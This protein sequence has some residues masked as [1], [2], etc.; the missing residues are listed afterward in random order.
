M[1]NKTDINYALSSSCT[2]SKINVNIDFKKVCFFCEKTNHQVCRNLLRVEIPSFWEPLEKLCNERN[3]SY[4]HMKIGGDF[5][6]LAVLEARY[7]KTCHALSI[8]QYNYTKKQND[9]ALYDNALINFHNVYF[10]PLIKSGRA[11]NMRTLLQKYQEQHII[12]GISPSDAEN[13]R[14]EKLK[15]C[16]TSKYGS[17]LIFASQKN[18]SEPQ[19]VYISDTDIVDVINT[20]Y[21]Y[22]K[23]Y[24]VT[25][26]NNSCQI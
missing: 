6:K 25:I 7:H 18:P 22:K 21:N 15:K 17:S 1:S 16:L 12:N 14:A 5:T 13:Y 26:L 11:I 20:A 3:D 4:L 2:I 8:K 9:L 19:I 10:H 23:Y 24:L